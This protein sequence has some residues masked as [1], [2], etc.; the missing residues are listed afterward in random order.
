MWI[1]RNCLT[2]VL[3][4]IVMKMRKSNPEK[5]YWVVSWWACACSK[6]DKSR[7]EVLGRFQICAILK[8]HN[9]IQHADESFGKIRENSDA[10]PFDTKLGHL[11]V[12]QLANLWPVFIGIGWNDIIFWFSE[13]RLPARPKWRPR[14]RVK[15]REFWKKIH[16]ELL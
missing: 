14:R 13:D 16:R 7:K 3:D 10:F 1:A 2:Y 5:G 15:N 11:R 4:Y 9:S 8:R 6:R 12:R